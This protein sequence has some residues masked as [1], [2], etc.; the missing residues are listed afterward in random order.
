MPLVRHLKI[1][2]LFCLLMPFIIKAQQT[3]AVT[4]HDSLLQHKALPGNCGNDVMLYR[5]RKDPAFKAKEDKMNSE[6]LG[7]QG[8]GTGG[9]VTLPVVVHIIN[10]NPAAITDAQVISGINDLN[11][12]F[13]KTGPY[14]ASKGADTK[15]KFCL[16]KKDP[17]GGITAGITRTTSYFGDHVNKDIEDSRL[18]NLIQWDPSRYINIWLVSSIDAESFANFS[19]GVWTRIG[20]AGYA[21][22]P[23][24]GGPLDGIVVSGFAILLAHEMGHYLGLYHTFAG[25]TCRNNNCSVDGDMVCDTPPDNSMLSSCGN[26][27]NSCHSDTL[28][29]H[30]NGNFFRDVPDQVT[31]FMDYGN[32]NC[33]NE[34]TQGQADRMMATISTQRSGLLQDEC[35]APCGDNISANFS[36][37]VAYPVMGA[38]INFTNTSAGAT[39]YQWLIDDA[40]VSSAVNFS[41]SFT[42]PGKYKVTLKAFNSATCFGAYTDYVIVNCGVTARFYTDKQTIAS[43]TSI[44]TDS[45]VFTNTSYN[46]QTYKWLIGNDQGMVEQLISRR[47]NLTYVFPEPANYQVRLVATNGACSDTT[48]FYTVPVLDPTAD[49]YL[50]GNAYCYQQTKVLTTVCVYN[51]GYAPIP[52][53]TPVTFYDG[54]PHLPGAQKLSPTFYLPDTVRGFCGR[55]DTHIVDVKYAHLDKLYMVFADSGKTVPVTLPNMPLIEKDYND[56]FFSVSGMRFTAAS[57]PATATL[58]PG[59]T[60]QLYA[61]ASPV[62][63]GGSISFLWSEPY[64]LSCTACRSPFLYADSD[65]TKRVIITSSYGCTDTAYTIIKVPP[66]DDYKVKI[67]KVLCASHDSMTVSFTLSNSFFR[68]VLPKKLKVSFY[69]GDPATSSAKLLQPVFSVSDTV[70]ALQKNFNVTVKLAGSG[71]LYAV[72][73]DSSLQVPVTLPN[74]GL[75]EAVYTNNSDSIFYQPITTI[76]DT[77]ICDGDV[78]E[79]YSAAGTYTDTLTG[80]KGCDS[81][82]IVHLQVRPV[83]RTNIFAEV[84][85]GIVYEGYSA[86]GTYTDTFMASNGCDSI[87]TLNLTVLPLFRQSLLA[88][89]CSGERYTMPSGAAISIAGIYTDTARYSGGCDSLISAITLTVIPVSRISTAAIICAGETYVLPSGRVVSSTGIYDDTLRY[90]PGCDS[91]ITTLDLTVISTTYFNKVISLCPGQFYTLPSGRVISSTGTYRDTL[92]SA[93]NCDSIVTNA[94]ATMHTSPVVIISKS[95]DINCIIGYS[96]LDASGG[97]SYRW[98]PG[99]SLSD[100]AVFNPIATPQQ[101]TMYKVTV[102]SPFDCSAEDSIEVVVNKGDAAGG[103]LL[104]SAFTPNNDGKNDCFGVKAWGFLSDLTF[105]IFDRKGVPVFETSDP[106]RCWDGSYKGTP[107][108]NA[109]F[110]YYI[111]AKTICGPIQRKGTVILIR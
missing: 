27:E 21:T 73:N 75:T 26:P 48:E 25:G 88:S 11:A 99:E 109:A 111:S 103:Y 59:D 98:S 63:F 92:R 102:T 42:L 15:I 29:N 52:P 30:S 10:T 86:S 2:L 74:T 78:F 58:L 34:F 41:H 32:Q 69:D 12:A 85:S 66:A 67:N 64:R 81:I 3:G 57:I 13:S 62:S 45:I 43:K 61:S 44:Y 46:G 106:S 19:C 100:S 49:G 47:V 22:M 72:V 7:A 91:S 97:V 101:T 77:S 1:V 60:L 33:S 108:G 18:K 50:Y 16:A 68:G 51:F 35:S 84:C 93:T 65:R 80:Y 95:Q 89:I 87:R 28:S 107:Q 20:V 38:V 6:I 70:F 90:I 96:S 110:V 82:R 79:G 39:T 40:L 76:T 71:S 83:A 53:N 23:P 56:N 104:P 24:A 54:D 55:C 5:M 17:D 4:F 8:R 94:N 36:R 9:I 37:D 14:S 31:N 105:K